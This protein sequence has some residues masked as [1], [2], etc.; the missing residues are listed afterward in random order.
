[1]LNLG[2]VIFFFVY[3]FI[4]FCF[5]YYREVLIWVLKLFRCDNKRS[6]IYL[7]NIDLYFFV[8]FFCSLDL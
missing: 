6:K 1:M 8:I 5:V 4:D 2:V 7:L 3:V